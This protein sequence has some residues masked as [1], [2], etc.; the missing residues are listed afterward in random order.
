MEK[1]KYIEE[2]KDF[3]EKLLRDNQKATKKMIAIEN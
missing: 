3:R 2:R 1:Q